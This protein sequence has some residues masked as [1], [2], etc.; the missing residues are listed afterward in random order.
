MKYRS[1]EPKSEK[2]AQEY[3]DWAI[4][5][6]K[7]DECINYRYAVVRKEDNALIGSCELAFTD[8]DPAELA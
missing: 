6:A 5:C 1:S 7:Q 8:K 3:L 2:E 4:K